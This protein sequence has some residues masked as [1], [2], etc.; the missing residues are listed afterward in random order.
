MS[1]QDR[2]QAHL[3]QLDKEVRTWRKQRANLLVSFHDYCDIFVT[4]A[5]NYEQLGLITWCAPA[6]QVPRP[7]QFREADLRS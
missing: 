6:F 4:C 7:Q 1:V 2:A 3:S 5:S